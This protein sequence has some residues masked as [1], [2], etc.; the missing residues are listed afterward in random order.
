M[1]GSPRGLSPIA[2]NLWKTDPSPPTMPFMRALLVVSVIVAAAF[3][4]PLQ[5]VSQPDWAA[6]DAELI[7]HFQSLV[8]IDTTDPP[9]GER[10]AVEYLKKVLG[11]GFGA[12]LA[13]GALHVIPRSSP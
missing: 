13:S 11:A 9:G 7:A 8:R 5:T 12:L 2:R 1:A 3:V 6:A 4:P 10:P